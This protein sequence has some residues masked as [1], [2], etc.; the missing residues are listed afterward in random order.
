[1]AVREFGGDHLHDVG[2]AVEHRKQKALPA[3]GFDE[4][5][6]F[7][8]VIFTEAARNAVGG[9]IGHTAAQWRT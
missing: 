8:L 3:D 1:V 6:P 7:C 9:V 2:S 5:G 4:V